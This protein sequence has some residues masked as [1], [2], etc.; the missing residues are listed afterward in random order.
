M[1]RISD[2]DGGTLA[3][4]VFGRR[5][6]GAA[7]ADSS[8]AGRSGT[9]V[10]PGHERGDRGAADG[11]WCG[12]AEL[13]AQMLAS[14][15]AA[16][17]EAL[18]LANFASVVPRDGNGK[19]RLDGKLP[20]DLTAHPDAQSGVAQEMLQRLAADMERFAAKKNASTSDVVLHCLSPALLDSLSAAVKAGSAVVLGDALRGLLLLQRGLQ[21]MRAS[22]LRFVRRT[23]SELL[24]VARHVTLPQAPD[25][26]RLLFCLR[27]SGGSWGGGGGGGQ[28]PTRK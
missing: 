19:E 9:M 1:P 6:G 20:F 2:F 18:P 22:D 15:A 8:G 14:M 13:D 10:L 21:L 23:S 25:A 7:V 28:Q 3:L 5:G 26:D 17:L 4:K 16:P 11:G 24:A 12:I 27:C